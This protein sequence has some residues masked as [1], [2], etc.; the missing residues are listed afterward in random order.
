MI[1]IYVTSDEVAPFVGMKDYIVGE[2]ARV[3][4]R[5]KEDRLGDMVIEFELTVFRIFKKKV[6]VREVWIS[7][8]EPEV[9]YD[10]RRPTD[11]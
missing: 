11:A 6:W 9:I 2:T 3:T 8:I 10:C 5:Y 7:F 4:G 1:K